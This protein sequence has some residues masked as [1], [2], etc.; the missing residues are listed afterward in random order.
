MSWPPVPRVPGLPRRAALQ[1]PPGPAGDVRSALPSPSRCAQ[2]PPL[3]CVLGQ[4]KQI[5]SG[6]NPRFPFWGAPK[7]AGTFLVTI[8]QSSPLSCGK[9]NPPF[10]SERNFISPSPFLYSGIREPLSVCEYGPPFSLQ[11]ASPAPVPRREAGQAGERGCCGG[12][13]GGSGGD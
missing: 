8:L 13:D 7:Q 10:P 2:R 4:H 3:E 6:Y 9:S 11:A 12:G 5:L 1:Q